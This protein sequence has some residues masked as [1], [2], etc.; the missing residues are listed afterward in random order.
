MCHLPQFSLWNIYWNDA[1]SNEKDNMDLFWHII[2]QELS[3][4]GKLFS[5]IERGYLTRK[6]ASVDIELPQVLG[7][8][9]DWGQKYHFM[10]RA[11]GATIQEAHQES[12]DF[13]KQ[14]TIAWIKIMTRV[15]HTYR[16]TGRSGG[17]TNVLRKQ[18]ANHLALALHSLQDSFSSGHTKRSNYN[19]VKCPGAIK[20]IYIYE[21]QDSHKH[22]QHDFDSASTNSILSR[23]AVYASAD[24]L[25][26]CAFSISVK[27]QQ[28]I[29]WHAF[30]K[31]WLK[32][33]V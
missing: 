30:E 7:H 8:R 3:I 1:S 31:Q 32:L 33:S 5:H 24:L 28:P 13:I 16:R 6:V 20:D 21:K 17:S 11:S 18:A 15:L 19:I 9:Y 2:Q 29:R 23:S 12:V 10:R 27:N 22:G 14:E 26:L 25:K 4:F